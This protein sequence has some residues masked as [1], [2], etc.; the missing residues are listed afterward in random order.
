MPF[1]ACTEMLEANADYLIA[2]AQRVNFTDTF[3]STYATAE[4]EKLAELAVSPS[5]Y[6]KAAGDV[7]GRKVRLTGQSGIP[8]TAAGNWTHAIFVNDTQS[9]VLWIS[10]GPAKTLN[11]G[12]TMQ[13]VTFDVV[14]TLA[15]VAAS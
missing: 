4:A 14:E 11:S 5:S 10:Q 6:T 9:K 15:P 1:F 2:N 8:I 7:S 12:D 3:T 13:F